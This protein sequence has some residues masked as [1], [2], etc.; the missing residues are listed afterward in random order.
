MNYCGVWTHQL[1]HIMLLIADEVRRARL[2]AHPAQRAAEDAG[3][4]HQPAG[5][6]RHHDQQPA[7][8]ASV[9]NTPECGRLLCCCDV[10][11]A[12]RSIVALL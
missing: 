7:S 6:R 8:L 5:R 3:S 9:L 12:L 11:K 1:A 10:K 4:R 2:L